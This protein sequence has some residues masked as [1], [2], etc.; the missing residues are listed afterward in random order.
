M[1]NVPLFRL[2]LGTFW[3]MVKVMDKINQTYY[4]AQRNEIKPDHQR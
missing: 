2:Y 3:L 1:K 4:K